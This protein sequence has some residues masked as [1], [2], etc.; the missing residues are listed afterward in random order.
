[1]TGHVFGISDSALTSLS[2]SSRV[3]IQR[4]LA[5]SSS[6]SSN[7]YAD[8]PISK[9]AAV[10]VLLYEGAGGELRVLLTTRSKELRSH[11]GQTALPGGKM[12]KTDAGVVESSE[13][14]FFSLS[15]PMEEANEEVA[16]P[17][18]SPHV[19]TL[20]TLD[21]FV[22]RYMVV[23]TPVVAFLDDLSVLEELRAAPGEVAHIFDHPLEALLDLEL[24]RK[25]ELVLLGSEHWPYEEELHNFTDALW[26]GCIYRLHRF[27]S[28][29]SPVKGLTADILM[30]I[31]KIAYARDAAFERWGPS[32]LKSFDEIQQ[33]IS[34]CSQPH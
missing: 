27:R 22:S 17:L 20:C 13:P 11:P 23:V 4:L 18:Y 16:L 30:E 19:H 25:E 34:A 1:M 29:A 6:E 24:V 31:A 26:L 28:T 14:F 33:A 21:P 9:L 32:Q 12:D 15:F 5:H 7:A 8:L 10:L 3:A 2:T